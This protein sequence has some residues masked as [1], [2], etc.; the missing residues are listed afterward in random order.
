MPIMLVVLIVLT[1]VILF[2]YLRYSL[3]ILRNLSRDYGVA[4]NTYHFPK[5]TLVLPVFNEE[6]MIGGKLQVSEIE[7]RTM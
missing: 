5:V 3:F 1:S 4:R 2:F 6:E 7:K